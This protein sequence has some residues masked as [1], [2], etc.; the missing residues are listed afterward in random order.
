[1]VSIDINLVLAWATL[2]TQNVVLNIIIII[3]IIP[4][5]VV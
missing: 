4:K 2:I 1:V 5:Y 3:I